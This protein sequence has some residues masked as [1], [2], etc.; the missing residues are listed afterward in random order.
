MP[1]L[2]TLAESAGVDPGTLRHYFADRTGAVRA[3]METL[4]PLGDEQKSHALALT[5]QPP[6]DAFTALLNRV[7][8]AWSGALGGMHAT[9]FVE[10]MLDRALGQAYLS[11]MLEPTLATI[12]AM[13]VHYRD[14]GTLQV[15]DAR[16]AALG[17]MAPLLL[18]CFHQHQLG[19]LACRP[20]EFDT[21]ITQ[22]VAGFVRGYSPVSP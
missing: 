5:A 13:L 1:S 14:A 3:A 10:G 20:L 8:L 7:A 15:P 9:G 21:F 17:L 12:E 18:A 6:R 22:H 16:V 2:R 19:G 11:T 4:L